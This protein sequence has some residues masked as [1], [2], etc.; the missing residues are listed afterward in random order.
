MT[1]VSSSASPFEG[2]EKEVING[3]MII[4]KR[5]RERTRPTSS[6]NSA[7]RHERIQKGKQGRK[8]IAREISEWG[9]DREIGSQT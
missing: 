3:E 2:Q 9:E 1:A 6:V 7:D 5:G 4:E 8:R